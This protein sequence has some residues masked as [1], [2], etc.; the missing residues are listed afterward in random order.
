MG[1]INTEREQ[2]PLYHWRKFKMLGV[3]ISGDLNLSEHNKANIAFS[4]KTVGWSLWTSWMSDG[5]Q[6]MTD[7]DT[8]QSTHIL[9]SEL[10]LC[11]NIIYQGG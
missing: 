3:I 5:K 7:V 10:L 2:T 9:L 1:E 8:L 11:A 6:M 4:K